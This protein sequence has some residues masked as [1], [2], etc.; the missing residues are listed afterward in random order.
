MLCLASIFI[1]G[2]GSLWIGFHQEFSH[3][4]EPEYHWCSNGFISSLL[5]NIKRWA[6]THRRG[7]KENIKYIKKMHGHYRLPF[8]SLLSKILLA[9]IPFSFSFPLSGERGRICACAPVCTHHIILEQLPQGA[10]LNV[11]FNVWSLIRSPFSAQENLN[12]E[13]VLSPR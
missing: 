12:N 10:E 7:C 6:S 8:S 5:P 1:F 13:P 4:A 11:Y 2:L 9:S 3:L